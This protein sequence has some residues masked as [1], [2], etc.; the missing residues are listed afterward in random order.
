MP[1]TGFFRR[2][3]FAANIF[4]SR[5]EIAWLSGRRKMNGEATDEDP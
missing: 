4:H 3:Q 2:L 5:P 1:M